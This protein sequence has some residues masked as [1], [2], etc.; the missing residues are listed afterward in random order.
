MLVLFKE[1]IC[2]I[3]KG[4]M[5]VAVF[6]RML[7]ARQREP[8]MMPAAVKKDCRKINCLSFRFKT[9]VSKFASQLLPRLSALVGRV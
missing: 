9:G 2:L 6:A 8:R 5:D 4:Q 7:T 3:P 1:R